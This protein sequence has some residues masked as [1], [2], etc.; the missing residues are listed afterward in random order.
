MSTILAYLSKQQAKVFDYD[1]LV[2]SDQEISKFNITR[3]KIE[4]KTAITPEL[5]F[6]RLK[7]TITM[8]FA[9]LQQSVSE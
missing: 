9:A 4:A 3:E 6:S 1:R 7:D 8:A 5:L 2:F